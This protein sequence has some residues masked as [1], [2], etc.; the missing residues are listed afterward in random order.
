MMFFQKPSQKICRLQKR[1]AD[2]QSEIESRDRIIQ[3]MQAE[4][5]SLSAVVARDRQRIQAECAA[6]GRQRAEAEGTLDESNSTGD[7]SIRQIVSAG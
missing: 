3:V 1:L 7:S 4:I 6:Y 5:D 2:L